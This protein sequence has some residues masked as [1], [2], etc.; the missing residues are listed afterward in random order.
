MDMIE[1][2]KSIFRRGSEFPPYIIDHWYCG[3]IMDVDNLRREGMEIEKWSQSGIP[4]PPEDGSIAFNPWTT[5]IIN[6]D[7][8]ECIDGLIPAIK[9]DGRIGLYEVTNISHPGMH[10]DGAPWDDGKRVTLKFVKSIK[11]DS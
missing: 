8:T 2:F 1:R 7:T 4:F 9:M 6:N 10:Y 5:G 3:W 11:N